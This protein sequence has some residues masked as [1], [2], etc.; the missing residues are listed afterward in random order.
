MKTNTTRQEAMAF[1]MA[2]PVASRQARMGRSPPGEGPG[3]TFQTAVWQCRVVL[4]QSRPLAQKVLDGSI[5]LGKAFKEA[6]PPQLLRPETQEQSR[7]KPS[8]PILNSM[9]APLDEIDP[10]ELN[11]FMRIFGIEDRP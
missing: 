4:R 2:H 8:L 1:A 5:A 9:R 10:A 7:T 11:E 3:R 6:R